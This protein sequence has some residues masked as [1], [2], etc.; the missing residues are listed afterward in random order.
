MESPLKFNIP[1]VF[2][3]V[4]AFPSFPSLMA[5]APRVRELIPGIFL[6]EKSWDVPFPWE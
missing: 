5:L 1:K 6:W 4:D 2:P 3:G